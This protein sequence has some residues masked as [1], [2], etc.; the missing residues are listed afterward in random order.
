MMQLVMMRI[1]RRVM[2]R[3]MRRIMRKIMRRIMRR[4]RRA[5]LDVNHIPVVQ[6]SHLHVG[7]SITSSLKLRYLNRIVIL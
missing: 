3:I 1:M 2:R 5:Q 6:L 7:T 4:M